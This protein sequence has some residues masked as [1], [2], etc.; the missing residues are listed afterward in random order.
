MLF[1]VYF[2]TLKFSFQPNLPSGFRSSQLSL[3][4][5]IWVDNRLSLG[6]TQLGIY[7]GRIVAIKHF[8][9]KAIDITRKVKKEL[10][11]VGRV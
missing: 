1:I 4:S 3:N 7:K 9:I 5:N 11:M 10:K 2:K 6:Y 8:P